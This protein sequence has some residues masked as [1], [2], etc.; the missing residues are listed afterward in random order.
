LHRSKSLIRS[1][2]GLGTSLFGL[3]LLK[4][5]SD[6]AQLSRSQGIKLFSVRPNFLGFSLLTTLS[7]LSPAGAPVTLS[8][9]R[10]AHLDNQRSSVS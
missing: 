4:K 5:V 9:K 10:L 3:S 1:I 7:G 8:A 2:F 6:A